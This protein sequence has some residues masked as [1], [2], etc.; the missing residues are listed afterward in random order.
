MIELELTR[1]AGRNETA[2]REGQRSSLRRAKRHRE[3][4][5]TVLLRRI[6]DRNWLSSS[7]ELEIRPSRR[8]SRLEGFPSVVDVGVG[9][10]EVWNVE[11]RNQ[12][13]FPRE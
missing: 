13:W 1:S 6:Q 12:L 3:R 8:D 7:D 9:V 10:E 11:E 2:S 5:R 4:E